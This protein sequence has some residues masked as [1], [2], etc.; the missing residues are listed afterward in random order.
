M[1][2]HLDHHQLRGLADTQ[3]GQRMAQVLATVDPAAPAA[4]QTPDG[5]AMLW[6]LVQ[7][8]QGHGLHAELDIGRYLVCAWLLGPDF[9][10]RLPAMQQILAEPRLSPSQRAD[11]IERLAGTVM[12]TL[13][14][15]AAA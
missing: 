5:Q 14:Q 10:T 4:L 1:A 3:F 2:L 15:G 11:A 13:R 9:D 7:R 12:D 6:Q 8:A